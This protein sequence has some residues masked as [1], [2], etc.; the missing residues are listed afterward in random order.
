TTTVERVFT[1]YGNDTTYVSI[2]NSGFKGDGDKVVN[3]A[4]DAKGGFTWVL[5]ELKALLE[6]Q[7]ST[8]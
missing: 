1:P 5:A 3:D 6:Q 4:L 7:A 8:S 2:K